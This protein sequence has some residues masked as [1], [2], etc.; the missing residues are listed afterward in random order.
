[1]FAAKGGFRLQLTSR[2]LV[3]TPRTLLLPYRQLVPKRTVKTPTIDW[4]PITSSVTN[5]SKAENQAKSPIFRRF[6]L[7]L[8]VAMPV[9]SFF[10]G[11]WQVKRLKWKTELI[12]KSEHLLAEPPLDGLPTHID[13]TVIKDFEFRR[14]K[15]KGHFDY[16]K[17]LF[18]GPRLKNGELGYLLITPFVRSDGG[19]PILIERG[20]IEKSKVIPSRRSKGYLAH[21]AMPV[22]EIEIQA[23]FRVMPTK[24][25]MQ[26]DHE[27][28][29]RLFHV[30]DVVAM[31]KETGALPV[32][33]Q[34]IYDLRDQPD[35]KSP[36]ESAEKA[37]SLKWSALFSPK[38]D[39]STEHIPV[40]ETDHT[41]EWQE[42]EFFN[43]GVPIAAIPKVTFTNNHM[44]Y[45]FTWFGV[46][47]ASTVL[48][49][50]T[51]YKKKDLLSAEKII[52]A[53]RKDMKKLF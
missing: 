28:G 30:P 45:L 21:L 25:W 43:Q 12:A 17:E 36:E 23:M 50:Y 3:G 40:S 44:Q 27:P 2:H 10:L 51:F 37:A 7:G 42:F 38:K 26:Y 1:M 11:C 18:L 24:S 13:P 35:W 34:M 22:G 16:S 31:S 41:L 4:K 29:T 5:L 33:A 53:K 19:E 8:M 47:L 39:H 49:F 15:I 6:I 14:F 46:S 9:I 32:Y 48:L 20:W 52:E